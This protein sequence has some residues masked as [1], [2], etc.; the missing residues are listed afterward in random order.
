MSG[1]HCRLACRIDARLL[2]YHWYQ[3]IT[4][5]IIIVIFCQCHHRPHCSHVHPLI[6]T[7]PTIASTVDVIHAN[8]TIPN[9]CCSFLFLGCMHAQQV[10]WWFNDGCSFVVQTTFLI[11]FSEWSLNSICSIFSL[12]PYASINP[13]RPPTP[14]TVPYS[15]SFSLIQTLEYHFSIKLMFHFWCITSFL[16]QSLDNIGFRDQAPLPGKC[17]ELREVESPFSFTYLV[18]MVAATMITIMMRRDTFGR[19]SFLWSGGLPVPTK[20]RGSSSK[21]FCLQSFAAAIFPVAGAPNVIQW[22]L[23]IKS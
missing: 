20:M 22:R 12:Y 15:Y 10:L 7:Q 17:Q 11:L 6:S 21:R 14:K 23:L 1:E 8:Y 3:L 16:L 18:M 5:I 19:S 9:P 4:I 13:L 2:S